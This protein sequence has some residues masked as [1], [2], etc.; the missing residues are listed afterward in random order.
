[1]PER[2]PP[3]REV[4]MYDVIVVGA[5]CAGAPL[6]MLLARRGAK[7]LLV[8]RAAFPS[9][10]PHGHFIHRH[11]PRRLHDWGVLPA[12]AAR[13]PGVERVVFDIGDFPLRV[14]NLTENGV[15]LGYGPRRMTLDKVLI[16]AA[17][18]AGTEFRDRFVVSEYA[19]SDGQVVGIRGRTIDGREIEERATITVG[20]DGRRS[21]LA[22]TVAAAAYHEVPPLLCFYFSYWSGVESAD[23]E[24]YARPA[25]RRVIFSFRTESDLFAVFAGLPMEEFPEIHRDVEGAFMRTIDLVPEY[26]SRV[27][28]GTREERLFGASDLPNFYRKAHGPGWALIGDA[29]VHKDPYMALGICDAF[30][31]VQFLADA[32]GAGL[33]GSQP[34]AAALGEFERKR[35]AASNADYQA[36]LAQA[37]FEPPNP[38]LLAMRAAV[39]DRPEEATRMFKASMGMI[40]PQ[41]FFNPENLGR[42]MSGAA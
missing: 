32:I 31:D 22:R 15:A 41:T 33:S 37:R 6:A 26:A 7:V 18:A 1:V 24:V 13:T 5:R 21:L 17:V 14:N 19:L 35:D 38:Q 30:R 20:A 25:Q 2:L 4:L 16:D 12:I 40:D 27:R 23:L 11:G 36:N 28:A 42:L 29:G 10:I 3:K 9:D 39:R 8:D 34:M